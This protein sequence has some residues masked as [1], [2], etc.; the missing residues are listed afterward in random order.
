MIYGDASELETL[1][2]EKIEGGWIG[3][4]VFNMLYRANTEWKIEAGGWIKANVNIN[5]SLD[6]GSGINLGPNIAWLRHLVWHE[7]MDMDIDNHLQADIW[8]LFIPDSSFIVIPN[9]SEGKIRVSR[10]QLVKKAGRLWY[11]HHKSH[12][13]YDKE[14]D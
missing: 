2:F 5:V 14:E 4:K 13:S 6:C 1:N 3:Y 9:H 11:R 10:A 12:D 7:S 8:Q